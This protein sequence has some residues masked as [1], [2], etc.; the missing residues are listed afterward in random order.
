MYQY[1][2]YNAGLGL[3]KALGLSL[4][5]GLEGAGLSLITAGLDHNTG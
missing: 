4:G 5:L 2:K 1:A 3:D